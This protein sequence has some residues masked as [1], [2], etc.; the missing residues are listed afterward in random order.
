[1]PDPIIKQL[2]NIELLTTKNISY[3]SAPP[4][5]SP[6]PHGIWSVIGIIEGGDVLACKDKATIRVPLQ[7]IRKVQSYSI[8]VVKENLKKV[9]KYGKKENSQEENHQK[10]EK[11]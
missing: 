1:M 11:R 8:D 10:R 7:D 5:N 3:L 9:R 2:D 4:G 6:S